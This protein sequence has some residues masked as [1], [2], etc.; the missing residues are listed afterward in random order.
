MEPRPVWNAVLSTTDAGVLEDL[1]ALDERLRDI[2]PRVR[3][4]SFRVY[5]E[6]LKANS[7]QDGVRSYSRALQ[8]VMLPIF[9][10]QLNGLRFDRVGPSRRQ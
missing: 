7:V 2:Q 10:D 3:D 5:D 9:R 4:A 1:R 8:L 6:Y